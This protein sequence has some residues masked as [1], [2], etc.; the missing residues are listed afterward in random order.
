MSRFTPFVALSYA[1]KLALVATLP[2]VLAVAL[3]GVWAMGLHMTWQLRYFN[4]DNPDS[5]LRLFRSNRDTGLIPLT[6]LCIA[7]LL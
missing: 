3:C 6:F 5:L 4:A 1:Q 7:I 2:L